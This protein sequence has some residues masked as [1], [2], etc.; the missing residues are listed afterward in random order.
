MSSEQKDEKNDGLCKNG[1]KEKAKPEYD[2]FCSW[3]CKGGYQSR[4]WRD[5]EKSSTK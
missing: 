2:G 4:A 1:C 3:T 5:M